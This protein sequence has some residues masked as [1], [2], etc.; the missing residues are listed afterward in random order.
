MGWQGQIGQTQ[1]SPKI[2][3]GIPRKVWNSRPE[4]EIP[5]GDPDMLYTVAAAAQ[6][7]VTWLEHVAATIRA[8]NGL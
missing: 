2:A 3:L 8:A 1:P 7:A 5:K 4:D 6:S